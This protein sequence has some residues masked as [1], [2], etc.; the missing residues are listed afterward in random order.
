MSI[1]GP[2]LKTVISIYN[3]P[4]LDYGV[5]HSG[6]A[7]YVCWCISYPIFMSKI[8]LIIE[9]LYKHG[10]LP[11]GHIGKWSPVMNFLPNATS[12]RNSIHV[13]M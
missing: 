4:F 3:S 10:F 1:Y 8:Y 13:F 11:K 7:L 2:P 5:L 6:I 9:L 12:I